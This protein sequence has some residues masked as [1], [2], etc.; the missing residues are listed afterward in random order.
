MS[1]TVEFI[2]LGPKANSFYDP[3]T[4]QKLVPGMVIEYSDK[5][6]KSKKVQDALRGGHLAYAKEEEF[7]QYRDKL[8]KDVNNIDVDSP[9]DAK[10]ES[11]EIWTEDELSSKNKETLIGILNNINEGLPEDKQ[12]SDNEIT[13]MKKA[14][15]V[16]TILELQEEEED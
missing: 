6:R 2:K 11:L 3:L 5:L 9:T 7:N 12:L 1:K 15:L 14:E 16:E 4:E 8:E 13:A 10:D